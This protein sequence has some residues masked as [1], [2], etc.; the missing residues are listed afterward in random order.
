MPNYVQVGGMQVKPHKKLQMIHQQKMSTLLQHHYHTEMS[1]VT[2][3]PPFLS[4][5]AHK[6]IRIGMWSKGMWPGWSLRCIPSQDIKRAP[7][8]LYIYECVFRFYVLRNTTYFFV[9]PT[10]FFPSILKFVDCFRLFGLCKFHVLR[11]VHIR[12]FIIFQ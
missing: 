6:Y 1:A 10:K 4:W 7:S 3:S 5:V 8:P 9:G 2:H 12:I 11:T